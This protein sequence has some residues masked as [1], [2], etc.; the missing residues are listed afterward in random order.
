MYN[1]LLII[2][3]IYW[4]WI[5]CCFCLGA[6]N[7]MYMGGEEMRKV[8]GRDNV[9]IRENLDKVTPSHLYYCSTTASVLVLFRTITAFKHCCFMYSKILTL[10]LNYRVS[11]ELLV[12]TVDFD[13]HGVLFKQS[14]VN[15]CMSEVLVLIMVWCPHTADILLR[16]HGPLVPPAVLPGHEAGLPSR[17]PA[18]VWARLPTRLR[19][20]RR[21]PGGAHGRPM[22]AAGSDC[23][24]SCPAPLLT[25]PEHFLERAN[26]LDSLAVTSWY[27]SGPIRTVNTAILQLVPVIRPVY[28]MRIHVLYR[29]CIQ[30]RKYIDSNDLQW[31]M[32]YLL[33]YIFIL[34]TSKAHSNNWWSVILSLWHA[35]I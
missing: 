26:T 23:M 18:A 14:K 28:M 17:W 8:L 35:S 30:M 7:A 24:M 32:M 25:W 12:L 21:Q 5:G 29:K 31:F 2:I 27:H 1:I 6:A 16:R 33:I 10:K 9:T 19:A 34:E 15:E 20:G 22:A 4:I 11:W 3:I 13:S